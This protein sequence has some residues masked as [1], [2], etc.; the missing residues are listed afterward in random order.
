MPVAISLCMCVQDRFDYM[1]AKLTTLLSFHQLHK[2]IPCAYCGSKQS[3]ILLHYF[4]GAIH[5]HPRVS[6]SIRPIY[7]KLLQVLCQQILHAPHAASSDSRCVK[8]DGAP[9]TTSLIMAPHSQAS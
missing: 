3:T 9:I 2:E 7:H 4:P 5:S 8:R 1:S 6:C